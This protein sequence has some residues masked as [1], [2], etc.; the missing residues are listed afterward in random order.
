MCL[1]CRKL[2]LDN[3]SFID[4]M[5]KPLINHNSTISVY[6]VKFSLR[7]SHAVYFASTN[8]IDFSQFIEVFNLWLSAM[9]LRPWACEQRYILMC[10]HVWLPDEKCANDDKQKN[11]MTVWLPMT[12]S[13]EKKI[14]SWLFCVSSARK[15]KTKK[16]WEI[17]YKFKICLSIERRNCTPKYLCD[18]WKI[19]I[20]F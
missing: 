7:I 5:H 8:K 16:I 17:N 2:H 6:I 1:P 4:S 11:N 20:I 10:K 12:M 14:W 3:F 15:K 9:R 13:F 19:I 18:N